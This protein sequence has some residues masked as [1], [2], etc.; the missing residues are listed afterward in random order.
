MGK[1]MPT[2]LKLNPIIRGFETRLVMEKGSI[3]VNNDFKLIG[4]PICTEMDDRSKK[5]DFM[6]SFDD[7]AGFYDWK[8]YNLFGRNFSES[9]IITVELNFSF[10]K[11]ITQ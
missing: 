4:Q 6:V 3:S 9:A 7:L 1:H 2:S 8:V 5:Y 10:H 11:L